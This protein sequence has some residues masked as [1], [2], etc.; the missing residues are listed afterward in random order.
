MRRARLSSARSGP[1]AVS[2][3]GWR[4]LCP[5]FLRPTAKS[6]WS[7]GRQL[8]SK[9]R[10]LR[11]RLAPRSR[12]EVFSH[13]YRRG[14]WRGRSFSGW[15]SDPEQ[16][17]LVRA[18]LPGLL[19]DIGARSVLDA[20]CGDFYWMK[21]CR[22][23]VEQYIGMDIV[24]ALIENNVRDHEAPGRRFIVGDVVA[25]AL[26]RVDVI[27]CRDC[28]VHLQTRDA[29]K[30][31]ENFQRSGSTFLLTTTFPELNGNEDIEQTGEWRR[32]NLTRPPFG[33]PPPMRTLNEGCT[34]A[35]GRYADKSLGLWRL[36][37]LNLG[38]PAG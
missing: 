26:P 7:K 5:P 24:P 18:Q 23:D 33:F 2:A 10:R 12:S 3:D 28:L 22:L 17:E 37:D 38:A 36:A 4:A 31:I 20:P 14:G 9:V 19:A 11:S 34:M 27:F 21:E 16:T 8:R 6:A 13:I 29:L 15:G 30:A 32:L 1:N 35:D 25:D